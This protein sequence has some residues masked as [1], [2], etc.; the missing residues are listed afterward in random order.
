MLRRET[1]KKRSIYWPYIDCFLAEFTAQH[2]G[3]AAFEQIMTRPSPLSVLGPVVQRLERAAHNGVVGGS[4]PS[5][6]TMAFV[7]ESSYAL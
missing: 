4:N 3:K 7:G 1:G 2:T 5:G 6:P